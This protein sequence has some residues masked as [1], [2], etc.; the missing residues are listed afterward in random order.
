[1]PQPEQ[2]E[3]LS[4][5][6]RAL[7]A[8]VWVRITTEQ[9]ELLE[10]WPELT[11]SAR[12]ARLRAL[13]VLVD[14]LMGTVDEQALLWSVTDL[15]RAF[16]AGAID[17]TG[18]TALSYDALATLAA[19]TY[20]DL[21]EATSGVTQTTKS[22]IRTLGKEHVADQLVRGGTATQAGRDLADRLADRGITA[23]TYSNGAR[24]GLD[25]YADM[26]LRTKSALAYNEGGFVSLTAAGTAWVEVFDGSQCGW[27]SHADS[28]KP[29]GTVRLLSQA[30][31]HPISHPRCRRSF[32]GRPDVTSERQ[33]Q[34]AAPSPSEPQRIDQAQVE[35]LQELQVARRAAARA[36]EGR[37]DR[38]AAR[39]L[40]ENVGRITSPAY[41]QRVA[42]RQVR[43]DRQ[44]RLAARE[45]RLAA[46]RS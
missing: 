38:N 17:M 11:R 6:L 40:E 27:T 28:D 34:R 9:E 36:L 43:L 31:A 41:A 33:A 15:P 46:R 2:I 4:A 24:H 32:G 44:R 12:V 8:G 23:V 26:L 25:D 13:Q 1:M 22:L 21:L 5:E 19:D 39:L 45:A 37:V 30:S 10:R 35:Q 7:Y 14:D 18:A 3:Q 29:N 20:S 16:L 42:S